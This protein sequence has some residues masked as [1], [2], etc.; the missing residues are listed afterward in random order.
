MNGETCGHDDS[1]KDGDDDDITL[2]ALDGFPNFT[3]IQNLPKVLHF[4]RNTC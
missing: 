2:R 3:Q 1:G 4:F